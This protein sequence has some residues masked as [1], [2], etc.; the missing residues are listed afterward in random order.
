MQYEMTR[1]LGR[2]RVVAFFSLYRMVAIGWTAFS[3]A[4]DRK[5]LSRFVCCIV[6][7][8]LNLQADETIPIVYD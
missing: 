6:S 1:P 2:N 7:A 4:Y 5:K 3:Q 8:L